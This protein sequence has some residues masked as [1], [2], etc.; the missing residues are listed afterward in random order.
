MSGIDE[1]TL[2]CYPWDS[3]YVDKAN[4]KLSYPKGDV[5]TSSSLSKWGTGSAFF[6]GLNSSN[7]LEIDSSVQIPANG[8]FTI[9]FQLYLTDRTNT[10]E[11]VNLQFNSSKR[12]RFWLTTTGLRFE[13]KVD[14]VQTVG[15]QADLS[16]L[17]T[18]TWQHIAI[19]RDGDVFLIYIDGYKRAGQ[20]TSADI[21]EENTRRMII[22]RNPYDTAWVLEGY[23]DEF[24]V[25]D[26]SR[27]QRVDYFTPPTSAYSATTTKL[28]GN[29]EHDARLL[30]FN[31]DTGVIESNTEESAGDYEVEVSESEKTVIVRQSDGESYGYGKVT[32]ITS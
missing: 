6:N 26:S 5:V 25:S 29:L 20:Q 28:S 18:N 2:A 16:Y 22:G 1:N 17:S 14:G 15:F 19:Q 8:D 13:S 24:R 7:A 30:I 21:W 31:E 12:W 9:D 10:T 32:P 3:D 11:L 27:Y 4:S 23:I